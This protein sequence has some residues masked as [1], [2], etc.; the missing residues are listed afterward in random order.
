MFLS[1]IRYYGSTESIPDMDQFET[2]LNLNSYP[3]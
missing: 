1:L 3:S 2:V